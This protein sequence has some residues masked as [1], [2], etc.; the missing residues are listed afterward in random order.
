[1]AVKTASSS[2][3][4]ALKPA[5]TRPKALGNGGEPYAAVTKQVSLAEFK[6]PSGGG[7]VRRIGI[8]P[9][10]PGS[11][12]KD[13]SSENVR[14]ASYD[15]LFPPN[16][17]VTDTNVVNHGGAIATGVPIELVFWGSAW[18]T[19]ANSAV[20]AQLVAAVTGLIAGPYFSAPGLTSRHSKNTARRALRSA[21]L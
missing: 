12:G 4:A 5:P 14:A 3:R 7:D 13:G 21:A 11:Q 19:P 17:G 15:L 8:V 10:Q 16:N 2:R 20:R 1:M 9:D 18:N 6:S